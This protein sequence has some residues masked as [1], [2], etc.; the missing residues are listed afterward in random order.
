VPFLANTWSMVLAPAKTPKEIVS[1]LNAE[2]KK[3]LA[4]PA[5]REKLESTGV[6]PGWGSAEDAAAFLASEVA[7]NAKVIKDAGIKLDA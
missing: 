4:T 1:R 7:R 2:I 5:I 3:I 6:L